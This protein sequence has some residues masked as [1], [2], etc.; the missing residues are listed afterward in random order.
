MRN[1]K[2]PLAHSIDLYLAHKRALGKQLVNDAKMLRV[3]DG[4]LFAQGVAELCQITPAH[5]EDFVASRSRHSPRSYNVLIGG[6]R[7]LFDW[8]V[9]QEA[10]PQSPLHCAS[11]RVTP[12]RQPFLFNAE[13]AQ[14]LLEVAGQLPSNPRARARGEIYRMIFAVLY[15]V[16]LRVGEVSRLCRQD[17]DVEHQLL[18]IRQTKFGKDR[19]VPFGPRMAQAL[20]AFLEREE[21]R[22][23]TIPTRG[24]RWCRAASPPLPSPFVC[25]WYAPALVPF[26]YRPDVTVVGSFHVPRPCQHIVD[27]R[28]PHHH[29]RVA[30]MRQST[31]RAFCDEQSEGVCPMSVTNAPLLGAVLTSFFND[32]LKLQKGLRPNSI[33]SYADAMR[34]FLQFAAKT[35]EKK[36]LCV[37]E[38]YCCSFTTRELVYRRRQ[39]C[40]RLTFD[41]IQTHVCIF[42]ERATNG[43]SVLSGK[44]RLR[45]SRSCS[46]N[47]CQG[48]R[49]TSPFSPAQGTRL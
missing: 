49:K 47:S 20:S 16:G 14:R 6:V 3:L 37:T 4:Y 30:G 46:P 25:R 48:P 5:L 21:S 24:S 38:P 34:L 18:V 40:G 26:R 1:A 33:R 8:L 31:L 41:S 43:G 42:T 23:G 27:G 15:G 22:C 11:R 44:K 13:Q 39:I 17:I 9:V 10:L 28:L 12:S 19:L 7:G 45:F 36:I 29:H 32:Y 35:G 2:G